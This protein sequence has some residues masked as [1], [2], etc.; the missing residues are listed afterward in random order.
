M[1]RRSWNS[2]IFVTLSASI[3]A[4]WVSLSSP[5]SLLDRA[6]LAQAQA[7]TAPTFRTGANYVR[8]DVY[9]TQNGKPVIDLRQDEF[10]VVEDGRRQEIDRFELINIR[11]GGPAPVFLEP[12]TVSAARQPIVDGR[13]RLFVLFL[14][15]PHVDDK[16]SATIREPLLNALRRSISDRDLVAVMTPD[17]T[18]NEL[19]FSTKTGALERFIERDRFWGE[20]SRLAGVDPFETQ[21]KRCYPFAPELVEELVARRREKR[22]MDAIQSLVEYLGNLREERKAILLFSSGWL[23]FEPTS[24][25]DSLGGRPPIAPPGTGSLPGNGTGGA[26]AQDDR[27]FMAA[28]F[29]ERM[30][31][32]NVDHEFVMNQVMAVANRANTSFYPIDPRG[33]AVFDD[34]DKVLGGASADMEKDRRNLSKR[35][36]ALREIADGTD[37]LAVVNTNSLDSGLRRI[38]DDLSSYYLL[39]YASNGVLDGKFHSIA[40][41]TSRPGVNIRARRGFLA[42]KPVSSSTALAG[43]AAPSPAAP[44][45][46]TLAAKSALDRLAASVRDVPAGAMAAVGWASRGTSIIPSFTIVGEVRDKTKGATIDVIVTSL[47]GAMAGSAR[48]PIAPGSGSTILSV[49]GAEAVRPGSYIALIRIQD[50]NGT[51]TLRV[52]VNVPEAPAGTG[53]IYYR[54]GQATGNRELATAD[55]RFRRSERIRIDVPGASEQV[56]DLRLLDRNGSPINLPLESSVRTDDNGVRWTSVS[57]SPAP[58]AAGDYLV[59]FATAGQRLLAPFRVVP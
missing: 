52:P 24:K 44:D 22:T 10:T 45:A 5:D 26:V 18:V 51:E 25:F 46:M 54:R 32:A 39:S 47:D 1:Y 38:V 17:M 49:A 55:L 56:G 41:R 4:L 40:V 8:V 29:A 31:L 3:L 16:G 28:C 9:A 20:R 57:L 33:L 35:L 43:T 37:G 2:S 11:D 21:L 53:A 14:D 50:D 36:T 48:G 12:A 13:T 34:V 6:L 27:E 59:E 42:S 58:L 30:V 7:P 15:R 19:T 23:R